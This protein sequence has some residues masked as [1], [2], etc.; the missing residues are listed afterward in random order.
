VS[1]DKYPD[2]FLI[3]EKVIGRRKQRKFIVPAELV[4]RIA[5]SVEEGTFVAPSEWEELDEIRD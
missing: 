4:H 3:Y 2:G 5:R 1:W